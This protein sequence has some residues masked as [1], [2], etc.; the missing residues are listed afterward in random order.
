M[1]SALP[2]LRVST[3]DRGQDAER[4]LEVIRPWAAREGVTLLD[5]VP[6]EGTSASKTDPRRRRICATGAVG[7]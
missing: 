1:I 6:D 2:Y 3:D 5:A 7:R 4:Q